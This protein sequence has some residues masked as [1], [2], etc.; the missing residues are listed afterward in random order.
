MKAPPA[1]AGRIHSDARLLAIATAPVPT[2]PREPWDGIKPRW[3]VIAAI[4]GLYTGIALAIG[5]GMAPASC[6]VQTPKGI[7]VHPRDLWKAR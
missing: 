2:V 5:Y 3:Y 1:D 6:L 7:L 4:A